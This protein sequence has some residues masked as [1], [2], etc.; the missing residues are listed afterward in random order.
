MHKALVLTLFLISISAMHA[1][2]LTDVKKKYLEGMTYFANYN[3]KGADS[4]FISIINMKLPKGSLFDP[5]AAR[6]YYFDGDIAFIRQDFKKAVDCYRT[7]AGLYFNQDIYSR[8]L[9]KLGRTLVLAGR[10]GE[11]IAVLEDYLYRYKDGDSLADHGYY[12]LARGFGMKNDYFRAISYYEFIITNYPLSALTFEVRNSITVL[13]DTIEKENL[14]RL[15]M[16]ENPTNIESLRNKGDKLTSQKEILQRMSRLLLIKQRL[17][18]IKAEK[19]EMLTRLKE[20]NGV[21]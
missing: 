19:V 9:Y 6:A 3:L 20:Q 12:W 7:V 1:Q 17:I 15:S 21:D 18:D 10:P 8:D 14:S 5:Y 11:G 4:N 13:Q 16:E 2:D